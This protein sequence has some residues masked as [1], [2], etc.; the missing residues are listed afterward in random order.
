MDAFL[1]EFKSNIRSRFD[2]TEPI[3]VEPRN[4]KKASE[5]VRSKYEDGELSPHIDLSRLERKTRFIIEDENRSF[6]EFSED[7]T[8]YLVHIAYSG[9]DK[10]LIEEDSFWEYISKQLK[11]LH[12]TSKI[13]QWLHVYLRHEDESIKHSKELGSKLFD[14]IANYD[15]RS[16]R[17]KVWQENID[18]LFESGKNNT[19]GKKL[20]EKANTIDEFIKSLRLSTELRESQF[21]ERIIKQMIN[22]AAQSFPRFLRQALNNLKVQNED[23]TYQNRSKE[24]VRYA[25]S[26]ILKVAGV[27]CKK[28]RKELIRKEFIDHLGDPRATYN[29]ANWSGV[30]N[31]SVTVFQ[32]WLSQR[33][34]EFFFEVVSKTEEQ[35]AKETH[36]R[37]RKKFWEAYLPFIENT[38]VVMGSKAEQMAKYLFSDKDFEELEYGRLKGANSR[39]SVFFLRVKGYDIVE[40]SHQGASRIWRVNNSP[41]EFRQRS[42]HVDK[43]RRNDTTSINR[44]IHQMSESYRW[45]NEMATW[46]RRNIGVEPTKSYRL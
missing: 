45:Q 46:I 44:F 12:R 26:K 30:D 6:N 17:V 29:Q 18:L 35:I 27:E 43:F 37:Y 19:I 38:W 22:T 31:E 28:E 20:L 36:W 11:S 1:N 7:E 4:L 3:S 41:L 40:Y 34:I 5:M 23:G 24:L 32:Q 42:I 16:K 15:G 2:I 9:D 21:V 25:A 10:K 13:S 14:I 8:K 39:Q 33:D